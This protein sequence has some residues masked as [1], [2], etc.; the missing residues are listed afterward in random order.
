MHT[1]QYVRRCKYI[2]A[3]DTLVKPYSYWCFLY[4]KDIDDEPV[5]IK[6]N[7]CSNSGIFFCAIG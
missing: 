6:A 7:T 4:S 3:V 5:L 1:V 2:V